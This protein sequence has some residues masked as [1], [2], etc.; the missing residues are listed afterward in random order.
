MNNYFGKMGYTIYKEELTKEQTEEIK[1]DL[2]VK[3][4]TGYNLVL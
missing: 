4:N 3:P 2:T 1:K